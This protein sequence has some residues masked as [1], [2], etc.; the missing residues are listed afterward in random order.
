MK[1]ST[2]PET[3]QVWTLSGGADLHTQNDGFQLVSL[4]TMSPR[5]RLSALLFG[6]VWL[7]VQGENQPPVWL[8]CERDVHVW[9]PRLR[10][11]FSKLRRKQ[12]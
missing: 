7:H 3:N 11:L 10:A 5:E 9:R 12:I 6:R 2:F 1:P 4:W 8:S